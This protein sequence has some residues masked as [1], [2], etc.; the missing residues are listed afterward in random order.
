VID[1]RQALLRGNGLVLKRISRRSSS[2]ELDGFV[3]GVGRTWVLLAA[4]SDTVALDGYIVIPL[5]D[6]EDVDDRGDKMPFVQRALTL[7]RS[8]PP[9]NPRVL[10]DLGDTAALMKGI[11]ATAPVITVFTER[12]DDDVCYVGVPMNVTATSFDLR[13]IRYDATWRSEPTMWHYDDVTRIDFADRYAAIIHAVASE[14]E[15]T[16]N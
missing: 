7:Q 11:A 13:E 2:D 12:L 14:S 5:A 8:W 9:V 6:V 3:L 4:L 15:P 16:V 1:R 10:I